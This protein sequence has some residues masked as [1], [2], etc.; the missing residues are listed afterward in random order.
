MK[1]VGAVLLAAGDSTRFGQPKQLVRVGT[2]NLLERSVRVAVEAGCSPIIV[3]LG[4][5]ADLIRKKCALKGVKVVFNHGWQEGM[6]SSIRIGVESLRDVDGV[7][8][9]V[10][11]MPAVTSCHVRALADSGEITGS[12]YAGRCGVPAYLPRSTFSALVRLQGD[13]GAR[14]LLQSAPS[15]ELPGGEFDIDTEE[16]LKVARQCFGW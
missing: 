3:V 1:R 7:V 9:M 16:D 6:A 14:D 2:E 12:S 5:S 13:A 8:V 15:I 11:D 10:C 4:A